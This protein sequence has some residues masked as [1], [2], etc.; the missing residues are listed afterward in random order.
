MYVC[1]LVRT[2]NAL[3]GLSVRTR[4]DHIQ[5]RAEQ[6]FLN[7]FITFIYLLCVWMYVAGLG[8]ES[9]LQKSVLSFDHMGLRD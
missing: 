5:P 7:V 8:L 2:D 9:T 4:D 1:C 6:I 3:L